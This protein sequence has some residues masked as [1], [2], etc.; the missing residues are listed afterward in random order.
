ML[1]PFI[2][3]GT[4]ADHACCQWS[5]GWEWCLWA[6]RAPGMELDFR[7]TGAASYGVTFD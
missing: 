1:P 3:K 6:W 4:I 7:L 5:I 2:V